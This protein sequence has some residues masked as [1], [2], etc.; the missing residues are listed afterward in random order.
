MTAELNRVFENNMALYK[1]QCEAVDKLHISMRYKEMFANRIFYRGIKH[2]EINELEE[3]AKPDSESLLILGKEFRCGFDMM[4]IIAV[5]AED[6]RQ[7]AQIVW[8]IMEKG[9]RLTKMHIFALLF[10]TRN[11]RQQVFD[12]EGN[13]L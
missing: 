3:I 1:E 12:F 8:E 9:I 5:Y 13:Q 4:R 2:V 7:R 11:H 10:K 6:E